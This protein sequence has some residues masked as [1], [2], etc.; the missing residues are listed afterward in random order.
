[1]R[2]AVEDDAEHVPHFA[3]VPVGGGPDV[4]DASA[5]TGRSSGKGDLDADVF[6]ALERKQ[7]I[8]DGEI[9]RR[10]AIAMRCACARRSR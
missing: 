6:V 4:R 8:D 7:M 9:A 1:M 5:A 3:L 10:L 2:M